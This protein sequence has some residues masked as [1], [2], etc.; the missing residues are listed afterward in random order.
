MGVP[1]PVGSHVSRGR[2][3]ECRCGHRFGGGV[4]ADSTMSTRARPYRPL[5]A[6]EA[7]MRGV[8][9]VG[10]GYSPLQAEEAGDLLAARIRPQRLGGV[11][12][13][14]SPGLHHAHQIGHGPGL[15]MIMGDV[16]SSRPLPGQDLPQV[17]GELLAPTRA[18]RARLDAGAILMRR[19]A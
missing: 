18:L 1:R 3:R 19:P 7:G 17:D 4:I 12:A 8:S 5:Q 14:K 6:G 9:S 15:P 10:P 2:G 16:Q 13:Q 11:E